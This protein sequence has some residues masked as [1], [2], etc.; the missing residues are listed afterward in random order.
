MTHPKKHHYNPR[1]YLERFESDDRKLWRLD[2][3]SAKQVQGNAK[4]LGYEKFWNRL[5]EP[6]ANFNANWVEYRIGD[7]DDASAKVI[8]RIIS[9][10]PPDNIA[11]LAAAISFM[12]NHQP[13]LKRQ[14]QIHHRERVANWTD[15]QFLIAGVAAALADWREYIPASYIVLTLPENR[16]SWRFLTSSNPLISHENKPR[17]LLPISSKHCVLLNNGEDLAQ[18]GNGYVSIKDEDSLS[19]INQQIIENSWQYIYSCRPDFDPL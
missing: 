13:R 15:D 18:Y 6:P 16:P 12:Q 1:Y 7:I 2:K 17:M 8:S 10:D 14:L 9:R 4:S 11:P 19:G 3:E 5:K